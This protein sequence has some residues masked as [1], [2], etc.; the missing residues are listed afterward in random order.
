M[1]IKCACFPHSKCV[2][3]FIF[4]VRTFGFCGVVVVVVVDFDDVLIRSFSSDDF[5][6]LSIFI[7]WL[8][9]RKNG[10]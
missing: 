6:S 7:Y 9:A 3:F 5:I 1:I 8:F 2:L 10:L 4:C